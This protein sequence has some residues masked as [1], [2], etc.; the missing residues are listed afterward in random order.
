MPARI[1][2]GSA[3]L[4]EQMKH[5]EN[6]YEFE[7][8]YNASKDTQEACMFFYKG[9]LEF[10]VREVEGGPKRLYLRP[11]SDDPE[12]PVTTKELVDRIIEMVNS[13]EKPTTVIKP[14]SYY[15]MYV[16][17]LQEALDTIHQWIHIPVKNWPKEYNTPHPYVGS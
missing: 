17:T 12:N 3:F 14:V 5:I 6:L 1:V 8:E 2:E 15:G 4:Q 11:N 9:D 13:G 16:D 7:T 10:L